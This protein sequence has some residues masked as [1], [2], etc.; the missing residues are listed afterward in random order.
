MVMRKGRRF[1]QVDHSMMMRV[2]VGSQTR[3]REH[4]SSGLLGRLEVTG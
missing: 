3:S 4:V 2:V 1:E